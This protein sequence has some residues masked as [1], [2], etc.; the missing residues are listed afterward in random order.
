MFVLKSPQGEVIERLESNGQQSVGEMFPDDSAPETVSLLDSGGAPSW[1][2]Q[3]P[4]WTLTSKVLLQITYRPAWQAIPEYTRLSVTSD[5][6]RR[7]CCDDNHKPVDF[8]SIVYTTEDILRVEHLHELSIR[9]IGPCKALRLYLKAQPMHIGEVPA[10]FHAELYKR[11]I[12][13]D[14]VTHGWDRL[15]EN[16][17]TLQNVD[18]PGPIVTF[19]IPCKQTA[20]Q[21]VPP[22]LWKVHLPKNSDVSLESI[23]VLHGALNVAHSA[24]THIYINGYQSWSFSGSI[25]KGAPQPG[26]ALFSVWSKAFNLGGSAPPVA[27]TE[28]VDEHQ[29]RC[30]PPQLAKDSYQSEFFACISADGHMPSSN[31][32]HLKRFPY[33]ALDESGGPALVVGWLSQH[34]QYGIV[35]VNKNLNSLAMHV[36]FDNTLLV[37]GVDTDWAYAEIVPPHGY[38]EEPMVHYLH[39]VASH[40]AA[41]PLENGPILTGWCSWYHYYTEITAAN[42]KDN[43]VVLQGM[44]NRVPTNV[45]IVDDGYMTAWGDWSSLKPNK[46]PGGLKG[47]ADDIRACGMRPGLWLAPFAADK[48]SRIAKQHPDWIILNDEGRVA[49]SAHCG[50]WFYGLDVTNPDVR[51]YVYSCI[52]RAVR[53]WGFTVLKIDFLYAACLKGNG[54]YD[55]S[56]SRAEAMT[57]ALQ[58][59][60][61]AAGPNVF[62]IGCG[63]PIGPSIGYVDANRI[64]ADTGPTWVPTLPLPYWDNGTLPSLRA[65]LRNSIS[66]APLGHRWWHNDPDCLLLGKTTKLTDVEVA[67]AAS[68]VAMTCGMLLL[69]DDLPKVPMD[70]MRIVSKIY[71]MTGATATVLDLH[72]TNDGMP[73]LLR[74]WCTDRYQPVIRPEDLPIERDHNHEATLLARQASFSV[75]SSSSIPSERRRNCIHVAEGMGT[76]TLLSISNWTNKA[77]VVRVPHSALLPPPAKGWRDGLPMT[78]DHGPIHRHG[79]HV[80]SFWSGDYAWMPDPRTEA[81]RQF[82]LRKLLQVHETE[83]FHLKSVDPKLPEYLGSTIHFSGGYEVSKIE[84]SKDQI[85]VQFRKTLYRLGYVYIF[86]PKVKLDT[87]EVTA[88]GAKVAFETVGNT[89]DARNQTA[90]VGRVIRFEVIVRGDGSLQDGEFVVRF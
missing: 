83:L 53:D 41:R 72:S 34:R 74:L 55:L 89:P 1:T 52:R 85:Y 21:S 46:F 6:A 48:H 59:I 90:V 16:A 68:I 17:D 80:F 14:H 23:T 69:S 35:Q 78:N 4:H 2:L 77:A 86:I 71:P 13:E 38:D 62:L 40:N 32:L 33:H 10:R 58:T 60:R 28:V 30:A 82:D 19:A 63:C 45:A 44:N 43:F 25:V 36:S 22:L 54:K 57:L 15:E 75:R 37:K 3:S 12:L 20:E 76:W 88:A 11:C 39:A 73:S 8:S 65:M 47:V 50:K 67:S 31:E 84:K 70:R 61:A 64:S 51:E 56:I 27:T 66:R 79:F 49:N 29:R 18:F 42:L 24:P 7:Y 81:G 9:G 5:Y 87:V 26:S